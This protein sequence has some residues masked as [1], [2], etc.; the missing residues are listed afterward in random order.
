MFELPYN[1]FYSHASKV[2]LKILQASLQQYMNQEQIYKWDFEEVEE[3]EIKLQT[4]A[5]S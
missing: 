3:P 2:I 4:F 5:V 1:C